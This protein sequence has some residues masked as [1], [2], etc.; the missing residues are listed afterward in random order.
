MGM[1]SLVKAIQSYSTVVR[2]KRTVQDV[3]LATMAELGELSEEVAIDSG[4]CYKKAGPDGV[5]GEA[6]DVIICILDLI[7]IANPQLTED[8]LVDIA[9]PKLMKWKCLTDTQIAQD[10]K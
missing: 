2:K 4:F 5:V 7:Y 9:I 3:L 1:T 10:N 8:Q 6:V